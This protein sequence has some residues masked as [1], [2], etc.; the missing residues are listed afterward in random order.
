MYSKQKL[1]AMRCI[2][3]FFTLPPKY[4][5]IASMNIEDNLINRRLDYRGFC[6]TKELLLITKSGIGNT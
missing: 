6:S 2:S 4:D 3:I 5:E 1:T